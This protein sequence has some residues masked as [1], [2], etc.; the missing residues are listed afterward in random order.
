MVGKYG[1]VID[2]DRCTGCHA[3]TIA[4]KV[5]N[6]F[7]TGSGIWVETVGGKHPD[8]PLGIYP[9]LRLYY[10][11]V[12]CMHCDQPP[13][14]DACPADAISKWQNGIV[15]IDKAKC[16]GCQACLSIC[17]YSALIY[18]SASNKMNKCNMCYQRLDEGF[19]PF[20]A[21]CCGPEAIFYGDISDRDSEVSRMIARRNAYT[22]KPELE[23]GPGVYY[24]APRNPR[25]AQQIHDRG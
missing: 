16:N 10:L 3:C 4:C 15:I 12:P 1:L 5:E 9:R 18:D 21:L 19:E 8:T 14:R 25:P 13:C 22:L 23:T 6:G 20:C 24:C 11:P 7:E 2:L 17:P